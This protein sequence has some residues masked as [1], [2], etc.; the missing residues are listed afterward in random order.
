[1]ADKGTPLWSL[2]FYR[3]YDAT[4]KA[5]HLQ[6]AR[7]SLQW[8]I[9][10]QYVGEDPEAR[11]SII[12]VN[13]SSGVAYG[14]WFRLSCSYGSAFFGLA[15][16][17]ELRGSKAASVA[18]RYVLDDLRP[19]DLRTLERIRA[20]AGRRTSHDIAEGWGRI[21]GFRRSMSLLAQTGARGSLR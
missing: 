19:A 1:M 8:C 4:C 11:G 14:R 7:R 9:D 3:L 17:E 2:L 10:N 18:R 15:A 6:A 5:E 16:M 20:T 12:G 21:R 13:V